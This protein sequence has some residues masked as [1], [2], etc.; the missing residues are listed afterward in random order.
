MKK[1]IDDVSVLVVEGCLVQK[2]STL[3]PPEDVYDFPEDLVKR[4]AGEKET[5]IA[6]RK[7]LEEKLKVL[8]KGMAKLRPYSR[9]NT[10]K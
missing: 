1:V 4:V 5:V 2:L 6:E 7:R 3:L 9:S 8:E 10:G